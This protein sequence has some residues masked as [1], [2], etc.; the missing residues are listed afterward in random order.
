M[1][2]IFFAGRMPDLCGA[3]FH[4]IDLATELVR[5]GHEIVFLTVLEIPKEGVVNSHT[6]LIKE[7]SDYVGFDV[8]NEEIQALLDEIA[9]LRQENLQLR[10]EQLDL[11]NSLGNR[12]QTPELIRNPNAIGNVDIS[13]LTLSRT[14]LTSNP[15][16]N[17]T[18]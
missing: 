10:Q 16:R 9:T 6:Y 2:L 15:L 11:I 8:N 14:P 13:T 5:R 3:F 4:D 12:N 7:S 18:I 17:I 1:R